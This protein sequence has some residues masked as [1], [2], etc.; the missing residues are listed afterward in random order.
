[1]IIG[2]LFI[3][4]TR[5]ILDFVDNM[6]E[7]KHLDCPPFP[8]DFWRTSNYFPVAD[9]PAHHLGPHKTLVLKELHNLKHWYNAKVMAGSSIVQNLAVYFGSKLQKRAYIP[10]TDSI[11]T[12]KSPNS[13]LDNCW[14]P[15]SSMPPN[16]SSNDYHQQV[17]R[18]DGYL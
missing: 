12:A 13:I 7:C 9:A 16:D 3:K 8:M 2:L 17:F 10:N 15:P 14:V 11:I 1:M 18:E 4:A 6:A 5:M